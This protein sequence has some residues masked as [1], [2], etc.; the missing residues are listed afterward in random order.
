MHEVDDFDPDSDLLSA[1]T[2]QTIFEGLARVRST[3]WQGVPFPPS[4]SYLTLNQHSPIT[5]DDRANRVSNPRFR[6]NYS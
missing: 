5:Q 2:L 1:F 3:T 6:V 4:S